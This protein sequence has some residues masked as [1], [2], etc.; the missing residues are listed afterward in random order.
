MKLVDS[1]RNCCGCGACTEICPHSAITMREDSDGFLYPKIDY[2][3]CVYCGSCIR[4][5]GYRNIQGSSWKEAYAAVSKCTDPEQSS[6]GGAAAAFSSA[7]IEAGGVVYGAAMVHENN[8]LSVKHLC[9]K[10]KNGLNLLLGSKYVQSSMQG[11]FN[12]VKNDLNNGLKVLFIGTPCQVAGIRG[13]LEKEYKNLLLIDIVCHGVPNISFFHSY[14]QYVEQKTNCIVRELQFRNKTQGWKL[15]GKITLESNN[16]YQKAEYFEPKES[17]YYDLFLQGYTYREN[18]YSCPFASDKRTGD[19]TIGDYWGVEVVQPEILQENGG[20][21]SFTKGIS[22]LVI[23][24]QHGEEL[25]TECR[26]DL[27]LYKSDYE[28]ISRYNEQLRKPKTAPKNR[29]YVI[30]LYR[31]QGYVGVEKWQKRNLFLRKIRRKIRAS[32]PKKI[33]RAIRK[34][35]GA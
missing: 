29:D 7:F 24:N 19:L 5:C 3:K 12:Q 31:E 26:K 23:N 32:V 13:Y 2:S 15:Y 16:G 35:I 9:V 8:L 28:K 30:K 34:M 17:S 18:C 6:S 25:L 4:H 14:L 11:I 1:D 22:C 33:K 20:P 21:F 10:S 27:Y